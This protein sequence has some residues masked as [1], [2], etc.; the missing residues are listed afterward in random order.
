MPFTQSQVSD[1][2]ELIAS[3]IRNVFTD[4]F[5]SDVADKVVDKIGFA[6]VK[7]KLEGQAEEIAELKETNAALLMKMDSCEQYSKMHNLRIFGLNENPNEN[8]NRVLS[9]FVRTKLN[10]DITE[11]DIDYCT[12]IGKPIAGKSRGILLRVANFRHK[13]QIM[14]NRRNLRGSRVFIADDLASRRHDLFKSIKADLGG[15]NVWIMDGR[16]FVK[17][18]GEK[19]CVNSIEEYNKAKN[20]RS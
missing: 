10:I 19:L 16:I 6:D 13:Q 7:T 12:R 1:I 9:D 17:I 8:L 5:I 4:D 18:R 3:T 15:K 20:G 2:K 11:D 14:K